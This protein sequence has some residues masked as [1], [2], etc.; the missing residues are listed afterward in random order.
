MGETRSAISKSKRGLGDLTKTVKAL[1]STIQI[2][3]RQVR[4]NA[5]SDDGGDLIRR[6]GKKLGTLQERKEQQ[7]SVDLVTIRD[8][9][10]A[11][12]DR[13]K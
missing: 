8:R 3:S 12:A 2:Y 1:P 6:R 5:D 4:H 13:V 7:S 9:Q 10:E 11:T